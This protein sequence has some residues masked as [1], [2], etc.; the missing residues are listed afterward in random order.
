MEKLGF[1]RLGSVVALMG[2]GVLLTNAAWSK[3]F[4][5]SR[6]DCVVQV[7]NSCV[8]ANASKR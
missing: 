2:G 4:E 6:N 3:A 1:G 5:D 7:N 8:I